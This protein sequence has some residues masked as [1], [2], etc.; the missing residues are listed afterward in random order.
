MPNQTPTSASQDANPKRQTIPPTTPNQ[1]PTKTPP[2]TQTKGEH[3]CL[4]ETQSKCQVTRPNANHTTGNRQPTEKGARE[5]K[6]TTKMRPFRQ[7]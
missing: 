7:K 2:E 5:P 1:T 6:R 3:Q 4:S